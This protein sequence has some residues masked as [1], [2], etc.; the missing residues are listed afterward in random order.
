[1]NGIL[2]LVH[3]PLGSAMLQCLKHIYGS[4]PDNIL[5]IDVND[6]DSKQL[7]HQRMHIWMKHKNYNGYLIINDLYG[8]SP[9]NIGQSFI[10]NLCHENNPYN[11]IMLTGL[12]L[13]MLIKAICHKNSPLEDMANKSLEGILNCSKLIKQDIQ[14]AAQKHNFHFTNI[15]KTEL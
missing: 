3:D 1:M 4:I 11:V 12:S 10:N 5:T 15:V 6:K 7:I 14:N 2:L 8:A 9:F 13:P